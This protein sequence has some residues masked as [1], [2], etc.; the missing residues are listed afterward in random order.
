M[1]ESQIKINH[2]AIIMDGNGR[3][4]KNRNR[5]R[6]WGHIR[7]ASIVS[8]IVEEADRLGMAKLTLYA[9]SSENWSR[10]V[11]E[12]KALFLLLRKFIRQERERIKKNNILFRV[13]GD[14]QGLP[15]DTKKL[16]KNL[17]EETA[18]NTGLKLT[19]AFGY[20]ARQEILNAANQFIKLNPAKEMTMEDISKNLYLP[21]LGDVDLL[22]RTGGDFR[23]SNFLLWQLAYAEL[24]FTETKWPDFTSDELASI[25]NTVKF[26]E[27]R[28]GSIESTPN[29]TQTVSLAKQNKEMLAFSHD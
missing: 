22:I 20:G 26:R 28:F 5:P 18:N 7:G 1:K 24:Y 16:I 3:W 27:R 21:D 9:F 8:T 4:A 10:P 12:V 2:L 19:F 13:M 29:M 15:L 6:V 23:V 17:E 11:G 25:I 14:I